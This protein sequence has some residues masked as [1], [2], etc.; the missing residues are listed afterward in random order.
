MARPREHDEKYEA[1]M[2]MLAIGKTV[3]EIGYELCLGK[4]TVWRMKFREPV[5]KALEAAGEIA[6]H[7]VA[8]DSAPHGL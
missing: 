3:R 2:G 8:E 6:A 1:V 4:S 5:K 7:V